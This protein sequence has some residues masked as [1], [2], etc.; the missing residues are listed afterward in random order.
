MNFAGGTGLVMNIER[1]YT[2]YLYMIYALTGESW[3]S[4][5]QLAKTIHGPVENRT[6]SAYT[7]SAHKNLLAWD[8]L[9]RQSHNN[10]AR[11]RVG[12]FRAAF[13]D[14]VHCCSAWR[15]HI[16]QGPRWKWY[17]VATV[18][19]SPERRAREEA[20]TKLWGLLR[21]G[22]L[23]HAFFDTSLR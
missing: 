21:Q 10:E 12:G 2:S 14:N 4:S 9:Q 11:I 7:F 3:R 19:T 22:C 23:T 18:Q 20:G 17:V 5:E 1:Q 6:W 16:E 13:L 8:N 15:T